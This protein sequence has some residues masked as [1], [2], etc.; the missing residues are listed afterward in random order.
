[1]HFPL[2]VEFASDKLPS[3]A[4]LRETLVRDKI[5]S[6]VTQLAS[7]TDKGTQLKDT[8]FFKFPLRVD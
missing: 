1:M 4:S 5:F 2:K 6:V 7:L 8:Q 3:L